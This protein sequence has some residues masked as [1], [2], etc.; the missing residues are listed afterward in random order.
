MVHDSNVDSFWPTS[1]SCWTN[2]ITAACD[3][4]PVGVGD[5]H[6]GTQDWPGRVVPSGR[7]VPSAPH[8]CHD[9]DATGLNSASGLYWKWISLQK[10]GP[11]DGYS[12]PSLTRHQT[13]SLS[14]TSFRVVM[15]RTTRMTCSGYIS[16]AP[17]GGCSCMYRLGTLLILLLHRARFPSLSA[18][19]FDEQTAHL[20]VLAQ[21]GRW[22]D[23][24][25]VGPNSRDVF[26]WSI[27]GGR[28]P[29]LVLRAARVFVALR[30]DLARID[31]P[32]C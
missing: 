32:V 20:H 6:D 5:Q 22:K 27:D 25:S 8:D 16:S 3:P 21:A 11:R 29:P 9:V 17:P 30:N 28:S 24:S 4:P 14:T 13:T 15:S 23:S 7:Q 26:T 12:R 19:S 1:S 18:V 2:R 31:V 10:R